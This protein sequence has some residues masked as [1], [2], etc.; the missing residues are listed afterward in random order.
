MSAR[1]PQTMT[2]WRWLWSVKRQAPSTIKRMSNLNYFHIVKW[3]KKAY[4]K[5]LENI[6]S[7]QHRGSIYCL[8]RQATGICSIYKPLESSDE[9]TPY[10][11]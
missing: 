5:S 6:L 10:R 3:Q 1:T 4:Q 2:A 11:R 9:R 7:C 8:L